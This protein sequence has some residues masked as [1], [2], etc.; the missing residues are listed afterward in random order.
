MLRIK[1]DRKLEHYA[2]AG[3][4][5]H[6]NEQRPRKHCDADSFPQTIG[7]CHQGKIAHYHGG[8][9]DEPLVMVLIHFSFAPWLLLFHGSRDIG[10]QI[11][12]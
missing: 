10:T 4:R 7:V 8:D 5:C 12:N 6:E 9:K 3:E 2:C 11:T 1:P